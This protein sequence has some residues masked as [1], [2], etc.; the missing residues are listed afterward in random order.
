M[1]GTPCYI[2]PEVFESRAYSKQG[3]I[4]SCGI[5]LYALLVGYLPFDDPDAKSLQKTICRGDYDYFNEDWKDMTVEAK[6]LIDKMLT[7]DPSKR[8][9]A[10]LALKHP[11]VAKRDTVP[12]KLHRSQTIEE[13]K[14][15]N[16]AKMRWK[17]FGHTI[18][19]TN[20]FRK[21]MK[22][23][24][25]RDENLLLTIASMGGSG[26]FGASNF[27]SMSESILAKK[28]QIYPDELGHYEAEFISD[29]IA[30]T[31][32]ITEADVYNNTELYNQL[33]A[34]ECSCIIQSEFPEFKVYG[35]SLVD[36]IVHMIGMNGACI[37]YKKHIVFLNDISMY[38]A[39]EIPETR[40]W[41]NFGGKWQCVH[42][43]TS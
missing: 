35:V 34:P 40:V 4:W 15:F 3:D 18:M 38:E 42:Y 24:Q 25:D 23:N 37:S 20:K 17:K 8:I 32:S 7:C 22:V 26:T 1:A 39:I 30:L 27:K 16:K 36:P 9:S 5:I 2:P 43:H 41:K 14:E 31:Q 10:K 29:V 11:W 21:L 19:L 33:S 28:I 6:D 12:S 13:M